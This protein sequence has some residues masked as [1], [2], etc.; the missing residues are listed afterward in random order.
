[1]KSGNFDSK[2]DTIREE[3]PAGN[4]QSPTVRAQDLNRDLDVPEHGPEDDMQFDDETEERP[5][6]NLEVKQVYG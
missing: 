5:G 3:E 2:F 1:M 4:H 6:E